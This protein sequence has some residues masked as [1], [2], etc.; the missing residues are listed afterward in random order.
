M[1]G[2]TIVYDL[3]KSTSYI[4]RRKAEHMIASG[5]LPH[6][7]GV[8]SRI[9]ENGDYLVSRSCST[10]LTLVKKDYII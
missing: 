2:N 3:T 7:E 8:I 1:I 6:G 10:G 5:R 4:Q 9:D